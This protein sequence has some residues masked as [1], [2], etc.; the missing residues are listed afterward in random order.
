VPA[1]AAGGDANA[2][3]ELFDA[4][5]PLGEGPEPVPVI[6]A[7]QLLSRERDVPA[8]LRGLA[9]AEELADEDLRPP[10]HRRRAAR[11]R[12][13]TARVV[14][15]SVT[16]DGPEGVRSRHRLGWLDDGRGWWCDAHPRTRE[17]ECR[18]ALAELVRPGPEPDPE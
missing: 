14:A 6:V 8:A 13:V 15:V 10:L 9:R 1:A 7:E 17:C 5:G 16:V 2:V 4:V 12:R 18:R 11:G 3:V